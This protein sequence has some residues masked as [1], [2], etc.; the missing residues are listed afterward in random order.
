MPAPFAATIIPAHN[1][2][3]TLENAVFSVLAQTGWDHKIV[4]VDD[5][6]TDSTSETIARLASAYPSVILPLRN[7]RNLKAG[8]SRNAAIEFIAS[9]FGADFPRPCD[10]G[11]FAA[12]LDA[13][14]ACLPGRF[15]AQRKFLQAR[16]ECRLCGGAML[17]K[18]HSDWLGKLVFPQEPGEC[19]ARSLFE[20]V[21]LP[22]TFF[23]PLSTLADPRM[24]FP[25][26]PLGEDWEFF[27]END[28]WLHFANAPDPVCSYFRHD[29]NS[30]CG[31]VDS[32]DSHATRIRKNYLLKSLG[33]LPSER[34]MKIHITV[35]PCKFWRMEEQGFFWE[36]AHSIEQEA[37]AWLAK[38]ENANRAAAYF[39]SACLRKTIESIKA[40]IRRAFLAGKPAR[41]RFTL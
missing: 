31:I 25:G 41:I 14:D 13:D 10:Q 8:P 39:P 19:Q 35:S 26:S 11:A 18:S 3:L 29:S 30:T 38:L 20:T 15:D 21:S 23:A 6:S 24:R 34:E 5:A 16:P 2:S 9:R 4:I 33:I 22:S 7:G 36:N 37:H 32:L 40:D 28:R 17:L 12:F 27:V 1:A